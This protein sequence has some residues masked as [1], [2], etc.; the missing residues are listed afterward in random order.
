MDIENLLNNSDFITALKWIGTILITGFIAQFGRKLA[1]H[2]IERAKL[3]RARRKASPSGSAEDSGKNQE[4]HE[5]TVPESKV[6]SPPQEVPSSKSEVNRDMAVA[7]T[8]EEIK[9]RKK[10]E[11]EQAKIE[12]KKLKA[13]KKRLKKEQ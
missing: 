2:L 3:R 8:D 1:E 5:I 11:K 10:L 13:E 4:I 6:I 12:K 9:A 7:G